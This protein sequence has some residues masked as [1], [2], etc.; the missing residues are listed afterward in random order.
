M[1]RRLAQLQSRIPCA[2]LSHSSALPDGKRDEDAQAR[3]RFYDSALWQRTRDA[4]LRRDPMCQCC[5]YGEVVTIGSHVDHWKPLAE[6]GHPTA[7]ENLVT[8]CS[9]CHSRKTMCERKVTRYPSIVPSTPRRL[10]IA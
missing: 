3:K 10:A 4:K 6:G 2:D 1:N 8:L 5:A 9:P 7:D